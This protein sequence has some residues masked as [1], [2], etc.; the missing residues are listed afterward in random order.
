[1]SIFVFLFSHLNKH[2]I[3]RQKLL[4]RLTLFFTKIKTSH[5]IKK[6]RPKLANMRKL[7]LVIF[8]WLNFCQIGNCQFATNTESNHDYYE[9]D[10]LRF[11]N[12][13]YLENLKT[14]TLHPKG[15][16]LAQP[17]LTLG[18]DHPL[19]LHFDIL[20]STMGNYMYSL[21]HCDY[22]WKQSELDPQEYLDGPCLLYTSPS[23]RDG[24]LSRM[25]SSA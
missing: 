17:I 10:F 21:I 9:I 12:H 1:M 2:C 24:L 4:A 20:D 13:N 16:P 8:I 19:E 22:N 6:F 5:G 25:P 14:V 3:H 7:A 23:P 11:N 18:E 15:W